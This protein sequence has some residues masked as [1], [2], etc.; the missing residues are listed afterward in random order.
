MDDTEKPIIKKKVGTE[1]AVG[2]EKKVDGGNQTDYY[3]AKKETQDGKETG[4]IIYTVTTSPEA[5]R[6]K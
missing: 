1:E 2:I 4:K 3:E 5:L 6:K